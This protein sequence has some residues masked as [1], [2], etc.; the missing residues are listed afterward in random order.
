MINTNPWLTVAEQAATTEVAPRARRPAPTG[1]SAPQPGVPVPGIADRL[2]RR[3][4][5][6][7][8]TLWW[9]GV[10]GGAG[11]TTLARLATGTRTANH[12]W[13]I[14]TAP[15]TT[16]RVALVARNNYSGLIAAQRAAI[17]WAS[18]SLGDSVQLVGLVLITDAPGRRPKTLR[19]LE[20]VI[21]GGV[22]RVWT[23]PWVEA[24][25]IAETPLD[26]PLPKEFHQLFAELSLTATSIPT[27]N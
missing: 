5:L 13:P 24:W 17:E 4:T 27:R 2:P 15:G 19:D 26:T 6:W 3:D 18:N 25:R 10:H 23:L 9:L 16:H 12:A 1:A 7:P 21:A 22:P 11:E 20:Q 8:A 14:P